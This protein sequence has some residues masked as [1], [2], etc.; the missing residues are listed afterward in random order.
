LFRDKGRLIRPSQ[1]CAKAYG[2]A[3]VFSEVVTLSET[4]YEELPIARLDPEWVKGNLG[5]HTYTRTDQFEV[6][7][8]NFAAKVSAGSTPGGHSGQEG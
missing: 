8:G 3:I 5:T 2:Y 4:E 7:D 1:D 6:I